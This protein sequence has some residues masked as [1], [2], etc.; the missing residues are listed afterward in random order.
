MT[1]QLTDTEDDGTAS[2]DEA[3]LHVEV[4][5]RESCPYEAT[6]R[7]RKVVSHLHRLEETGVI[8]DL[9]VDC[10]GVRS[11]ISPDCST[12]Y[13]TYER[14]AE[15]ATEAGCTLEPGFDHVE[16]TSM[17]GEG[18]D[19]SLVLPILCLAVSRGDVLE[20]VFP[21]ARGEEIFTV[22]DGL[23]ALE[24]GTLKHVAARDSTDWT[25]PGTPTDIS[26]SGQ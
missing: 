13:D 18:E 25:R 12:A 22:T 23:R 11:H 8:G 21:H 9:S 20:A 1:S 10:W 17:V 2:D 5:L 6:Q 4:F 24:T 3:E 14:L 7:Q 15:W 19:E 26:E 16:R